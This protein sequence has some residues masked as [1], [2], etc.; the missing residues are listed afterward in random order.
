MA[1]DAKRDGATRA[2]SGGASAP[3]SPDARRAR[4]RTLRIAL[5]LS[6]WAPLATGVAVATSRSTTQL[7]DFVRRTV[8]LAAIA[9]SYL[10]FARGGRPGAA[11]ADLARLE[12]RARW[13]VVAALAGS[14]AVLAGLAAARGGEGFRPAGNVTIG[15][16]VALLGL[17]T[18]GWL[19]RRYARFE[20]ESPSPVIAGQRALYGAKSV[21]DACVALALATV[22]AAPA[23][24][25]A[26][27]ADLLGSWLVAAYLAWSAAK[28][29]RAIGRGP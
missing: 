12:R 6:A 8:E 16:A 20:R 26:R 15:L 23:S 1:R 17:L 21:V 13:A 24:P 25:A 11:A 18:N 9:A 7:A 22:A 5:A 28:E 19:W 3:L 27:W 10:A 29:A 4:L 2:T 14:A